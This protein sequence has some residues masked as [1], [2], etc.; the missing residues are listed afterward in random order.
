[1]NVEDEMAEVLRMR[2]ETQ[3][4]IIEDVLRSMVVEDLQRIKERM[5]DPIIGFLDSGTGDIAQRDEDILR[6]EWHPD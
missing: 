5:N 2:A 3:N 1:L 6:D 4:T